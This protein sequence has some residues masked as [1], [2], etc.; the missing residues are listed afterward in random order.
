MHFPY[1]LTTLAMAAAVSCQNLAIPARN[2]P[3][4][5][6]KAPMSISGFR[7]MANHEYDRG[8]PCNSDQDTGSASAVFILEDGATLS[9]AI[10]G[11]NALEGVHCKGRC[12]L[13]NV[14]FRDVCEDAI[15]L[16]GN[17]DVL[18]EGG[19]AQEAKDKVIQHNGRGTVTIRKFTVINSGKLYRG[20][21]DCT[22][23]GE[24]RNVKV[25]NVR[26]RGVDTLV[27]INSNF[28][29][30]A[31]ISGTCGSGVKKVCQ[32]FKG[33]QKGQGDSPKVTTTANCRGQTSLGSC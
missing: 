29:D 25:E 11:A 7:D 20:C 14:W 6:L 16:L 23:N 24:P 3:V 5:S 2:G 26:A 32:E 21:G 15:S 8:R 4:Q 13:R 9:N 19:G 28:G 17:G 22:K 1:S 10:I 12:T 27:G 18:I 31:T 30:V 33:V